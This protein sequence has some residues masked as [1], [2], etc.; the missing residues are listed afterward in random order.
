MA[1]YHCPA[2]AHR[3]TAVYDSR[4]NDAGWIRRRRKCPECKHRFTTY[5]LTDE[6]VERL[7]RDSRALAALKQILREP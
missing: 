6:T 5:E 7:S 1:G 4:T 2:C 3:I